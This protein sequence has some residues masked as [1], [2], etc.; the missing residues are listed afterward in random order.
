MSSVDTDGPKPQEGEGPRGSLNRDLFFIGYAVF[1]TTLAQDKVIGGLPIRLWLK[2]H[3]HVDAPT[4]SAFLFFA[5]LAWYLKPL[6]GLLVDA[7]PLFGTR[8]RWYMI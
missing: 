8:R 2:N 4:L 6:F 5:G 1:I 7:F 3:L